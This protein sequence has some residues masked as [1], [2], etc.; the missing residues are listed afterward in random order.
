MKRSLGY[1]LSLVLIVGSMFSCNKDEGLGGTSSIEGFVYVT[2]HD[3]SRSEITDVTFSNGDQ[4]EHGDY[5]ILNTP[6]VNQLFYIWYDNPTWISSGD[7]QLQGRTGIKVSFNYS[8]SNIEVANNT[9]AAILAETSVFSITQMN[10]ILTF[11]STVEGEC[12][13]A[14]DVSSPFSFDIAQQG[15]NGILGQE[16]VAVDESVFIQYGEDETVVFDDE[17]KTSSTGGYRFTNLRKGQYVLSVYSKDTTNG[18]STVIQQ[19]IEVD[20]NKTTY[21]AIDFHIFK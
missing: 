18:G 16:K 8:D 17:F 4:V 3:F 15:A 12:H 11:T 1:S 19:I 6:D 7:P 2:D 10:D 20:K 21:T 13:D 5:W 9:K 14:E